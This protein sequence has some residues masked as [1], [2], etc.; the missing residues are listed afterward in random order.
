[1]YKIDF[2]LGENK[3]LYS[4]SRKEVN[5]EIS[6]AYASNN[7]KLSCQLM[8]KLINDKILAC[9]ISND[10]I[11]KINSIVFDP[12]NELSFLYY[13]NNMINT[14]KVYN[15]YSE[16]APNKKVSL[17]CIIDMSTHFACL[18]Y[19]SESNKFGELKNFMLECKPNDFYMGIKYISNKK[20]YSGFCATYSYEMRIIIFDEN[21]NVKKVNEENNKC[22]TNIHYV[23]YDKSENLLC[24]FLIYDEYYQNFFISRNINGTFD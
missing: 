13:S 2:E 3:L 17:V 23:D 14:E 15:I 24:S 11:N 18:L 6:E 10:D 21:F 22:Y 12:E 8:S 19:F 16:I 5:E 20:E 9:F 1:M 4:I 7:K